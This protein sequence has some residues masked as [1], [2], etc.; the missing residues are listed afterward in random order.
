M[1]I[2]PDFLDHWKTRLLVDLLDDP[3]APIYL[4]RLWSHCQNRK[5]HR[6]SMGFLDVICSVC[7][8]PHKV[9]V[10]SKAL[11]DAGFVR[12]ENDEV[13]AHDWDALNA[14]LI[15]NWENGAKGGRPKKEPTKKPMANPSITHQEPINNPSITDR[16]DKIEKRRESKKEIEKNLEGIPESR[17]VLLQRWLDYK[18]ERRETYKPTGF[19][20]LMRK[21]ETTSNE[22]FEAIIE[23]SISNNYAGLFPLRTREKKREADAPQKMKVKF[24]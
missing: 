5:T 13:V 17:R 22:D 11:L 4:I 10:F 24:I 19:T 23:Q 20:S 1:I 2:Q 3:C 8:A 7:H 15:A 16:E 21:W 12:I 6:F 9:D 14:S 18:A